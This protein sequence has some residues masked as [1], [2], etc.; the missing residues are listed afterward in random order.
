EK[1]VHHLTLFVTSGY[2]SWRTHSKKIARLLEAGSIQLGNHTVRHKDLT[3]LSSQQVKNELM[4]CHN[5]LLD[6]FGYDARPYFRPPYG[7]S[8]AKVRSAAADLG[9]T[10]PTMWYGSFGD[11]FGV[12]DD[13]IVEFAKKWIADGRIVIDHCNKLKSQRALIQIQQIMKSRGL[14]SVTLTEA[15][16][17]NFK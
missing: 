6:E 10:V 1:G 16:G 13:R 5:F 15:F 8:N 17:P 3:T 9:Y 7:I 11:N 12:S 4:G 14:Q 2:D